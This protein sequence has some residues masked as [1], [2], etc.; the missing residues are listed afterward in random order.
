[1]SGD[2][3]G[4]GIKRPRKLSRA[5]VG[6]GPLRELKNLLYEVYTAADAPSLDQIAAAIRE[7]DT[8]IGAPNRD[9]IRRCI[10][11]PGVPAQQGDVVAIAVVLG[12]RAR[13]DSDDMASRTADLWLKARLADPPGKPLSE[14]SDP[15]A[16]EVHPAVNTERIY[17]ARALPALPVYVERDHDARLRAIAAEA[18]GGVSRLVVLTGG[19]STG[20]TRACW[21]VLH[22]LPDERRLW[23]PF[24]P[25]PEAAL[26]A[27]EQLA[28]RTVVWLNE[29]Q[30]YLLTTFDLGERLAA[31]LRTL[32]DDQSRAPVLVLGTMWP[33]YWNTR[34]PPRDFH[35]WRRR[36]G[37]G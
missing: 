21:E 6:P 19:S 12:R 18:V 36:R 25:R 27:I 35:R 5:V 33:G 1:M 11:D 14:V 37:R 16:L 2:T 4:S 23:H 8:L 7:D 30:H 3:E 34:G 32:L 13:W 29:A 26:A 31:K 9:T 17:T 24:D 15:F 28:Q 10:S 20:K 22:R